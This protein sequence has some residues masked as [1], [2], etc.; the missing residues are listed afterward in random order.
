MYNMEMEWYAEQ[1][2]RQGGHQKQGRLDCSRSQSCVLA[3]DAKQ[4]I[5]ALGVA[6]CVSKT[7]KEAVLC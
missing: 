2:G 5:Q 4:R 6:V 1:R 3:C 7:V